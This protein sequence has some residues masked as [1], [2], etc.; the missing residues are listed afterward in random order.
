MEVNGSLLIL[1]LN[2]SLHAQRTVRPNRNVSVGSRGRSVAGP[3]KGSGGV[4]SHTWELP[5]GFFPGRSFYRKIAGRGWQAAGCDFVLIGW[6]DNRA[7]FQASCAQPEATFPH[8]GGGLSS[9]RR[10]RRYCLN[11]PS[12]GTRI[13]P[14]SCTAAV[15]AAAK[16]LQS[17]PTLVTP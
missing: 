12:R 13:L 11:I 4:C 17:C 7:Q 3:S 5:G 16:S 14:H 1:L 15:A 10:I 2:S 8:L 6:W 9:C